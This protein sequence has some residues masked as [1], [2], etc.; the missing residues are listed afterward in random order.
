MVD[1]YI[2][3][4]NLSVFKTELENHILPACPTTTDGT[5]VLQCVVSSGVPTY[6]WV[7]Y[8]DPGQS[9]MMVVDPVE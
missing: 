9:V 7:P 3:L 8:A 6:S 1:K 5:F 2:T 4:E